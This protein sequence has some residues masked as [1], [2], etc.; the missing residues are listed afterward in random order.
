MSKRGALQQIIK[1][2]SHREWYHQRFDGSPMFIYIIADA[3]TRTEARKPKGTEARVRVCFFESEKA[4]WYLD[5]A[6]VQRGAD[7][8]IQKAKQDT[9]CRLSTRLI[10]KWKKDEYTFE[11][12]FEQSKKIA[13][14][15]LSDRALYAWYKKTYTA[16]V[17]R[18]TS[19]SVIDHFALG[20]D[21]YVADLIKKEAGPFHRESEFTEIFSTATAPVHQSFINEA[22]IALMKIA[23]LPK[24]QQPKALEKYQRNYFWIHNNYTSAHILSVDDLAKE[25]TEWA[26]S[27]KSD[28]KKKITFL[29]GTPSRNTAKKKKLFSRYHFSS[30]LRSLL[31]ISEDF[32]RWQDERKRATYFNIHIGSGILTEMAERR[33]TDSTLTKY[34][35]P[36]EVEGWFLRGRIQVSVL[37]ERKKGCAFVVSK[38]GCELLTGRDAV[39][40]RQALLPRKDQE[41][42]SDFRGLSAS[43]GR[44]SGT[45]RI[46]R[47]VT[48]VGK[49]KKGDILVAV[50]TRP[51]YIMG[52]KKAAAIV[53]NEGGITCHAAI[54]SRE[55][56]IPCVIATKIATEVLHDGDIVDVN[57]NHGVVKITKRA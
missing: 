49:V 42:I 36:T 52:I 32:T 56:G 47:S 8:M 2:L 29:Q 40:L 44:V 5:M 45:V 1:Q 55:L 33:S 54:V 51:D 17:R 3:E 39:V 30:E 18:L 24:R 14:H 50:M 23:L 25:V 12:L 57:A 21:R 31:K 16:A 20:T 53:T 19:S 35:L 22:E 46:V 7:A 28:L 4:D 26:K 48:E 9:V 6:D 34:V 43:T 38:I 13:L 10:Q 27:S 11:K 37:Q 15:D 41:E